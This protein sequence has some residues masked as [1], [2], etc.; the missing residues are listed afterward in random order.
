MC[1][2]RFIA[3]IQCDPDVGSLTTYQTGAE[4]DDDQPTYDADRKSGGESFSGDMPYF[5][6]PTISAPVHIANKPHQET[7]AAIR[8]IFM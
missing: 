8:M 4:H 7:I 3:D 2:Q 5:H 6:P 1:F